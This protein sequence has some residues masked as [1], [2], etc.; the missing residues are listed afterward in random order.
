MQA[1]IQTAGLRALSLALVTD[2][3]QSTSEF[4]LSLPLGSGLISK[5]SL[6]QPTM[7]LTLP[8]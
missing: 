8:L 4:H 6:Q 5:N 2:S 7:L 3:G 1:R